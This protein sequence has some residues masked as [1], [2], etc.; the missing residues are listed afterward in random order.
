MSTVTI[1]VSHDGW[2]FQYN[3]DSILTGA[4]LYSASVAYNDI[5]N[6]SNATAYLQFEVP[7]AV[8][9]KKITRATLH[10]YVDDDY[11]YVAYGNLNVAY[12]P[13]LIGSLDGVSYNTVNDYTIGD[14]KVVKRRFD[15]PQWIAE[16]ITDIFQN[17]IVNDIFAV[18]VSCG[19]PSSSNQFLTYL[20]GKSGNNA[21]YLTV[22]YEEV[23]QL[24]PTISYPSGVYV[25]E[26][27]PVTFSW[28]YNSLTQ[29][30]QANATIQW[31]MKDTTD[32]NTIA[33]NSPAHY[34]ICEA[35]FPQGTIEWRVCITNSI[36]E[37]SAYS[38]TAEFTVQG[39]PPIPVIVD[40]ENKC[41]PCIQ[42]NAADQ[43]AYEIEL[44]SGD[45]KLIQETVYSGVSE[46]RPQMFLSGTY[47]V[48]IRTRNSIDLWSDKASKTFVINPPV[49]VI[50][51]LTVRQEGARVILD[52]EHEAETKLAIIRNGKII[53]IT[54]DA[55][56][57]DD[58]V[59][60]GTEYEY[61]VRAY[62]DGYADSAT[63]SAMVC[64]E[65]F[66]L[67]GKEKEVNC[68][69][70]EQ[71]F[72]SLS[73]QDEQEGELIRYDGRK[74]PVLE[75]GTS[76]SRVITRA[77]TVSDEQY[78]DLLEISEEPAYYKD[79]E[80]NGFA[81]A[82]SISSCNRYMGM[83][84]SLTLTMTQIDEEEVLLNE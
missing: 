71:K 45:A 68:T 4:K 18:L 59:L 27:E 62:A 47:T 67:K 32:W 31:R 14:A 35:I 77:V 22:E 5:G 57:E 73:I 38:E 50:P 82:V 30:T 36:A 53:A 54:Y 81:C 6:S 44:T 17:N 48:T 72:L 61:K 83:K 39:K 20:G 60:S 55:S 56:Y 33:V 2:I 25:R 78:R 76:K 49:P 41:L 28:I 10:Y 23:E 64:Y 37:T 75:T 3:P 80:G 43:C 40:V 51:K 13:Y 52:V 84:Y 12:N 8:L 24:P 46:Y 19:V 58:L 34:Y 66:I 26:G 9:F 69:V 42:W 65:G 21:S 16:D 29:A 11:I 15:R 63:V 1:P 70:S 79:R 7:Q 74:F